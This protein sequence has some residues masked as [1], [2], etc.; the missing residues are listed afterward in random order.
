[1]SY[2]KQ[3]L[4]QLLAKAIPTSGTN[5]VD[6]R[7]LRELLEAS[8]DLRVGKDVESIDSKFE[9]NRLN[10][11]SS[12]GICSVK[13]DADSLSSTFDAGF[14][15]LAFENVEGTITKTVIIQKLDT[16]TDALTS[17][18]LVEREN[19]AAENLLSEDEREQEQDSHEKID[20]E[21]VVSITEFD[22][23]MEQL[24]IEKGN[25]RFFFACLEGKCSIKR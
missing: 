9:Q 18:I 21:I 16:T 11:Q 25:F 1:M 14:E 8:I 17:S 13:S 2:S 7:A 6:F 10:Y 22:G 5:H 4:E 12:S 19:F 15:D 24:E 3:H 23:G 20:D